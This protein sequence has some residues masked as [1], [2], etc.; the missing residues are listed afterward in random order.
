MVGGV[1]VRAHVFEDLVISTRSRPRHPLLDHARSERLGA[2]NLTDRLD[3]LN[4][5][6][7]IVGV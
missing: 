1:A 3:A 4:H 7:H 2:Q 6:T 5:R